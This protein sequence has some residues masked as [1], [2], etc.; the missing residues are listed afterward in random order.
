MSESEDRVFQREMVMLTA[1]QS[2]KDSLTELLELYAKR[3]PGEKAPP[4]I[5]QHLHENFAIAKHAMKIF[6]QRWG[7]DDEIVT[8]S[9]RIFNMPVEKKDP[10]NIH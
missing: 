6:R 2:Y 7:N 1:L 5:A 9:E 3:F 8:R 10:E 4:E